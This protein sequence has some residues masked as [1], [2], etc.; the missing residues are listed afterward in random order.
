MCLLSGA[1]EWLTTCLSLWSAEKR[2]VVNKLINIPSI[3]Y[4]LTYT[5][6]NRKY[7]VGCV[8]FHL[9]LAAVSFAQMSYYGG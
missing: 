7:H 2:E 6:V 1:P 4:A 5:Y 3:P 9:I 8:C